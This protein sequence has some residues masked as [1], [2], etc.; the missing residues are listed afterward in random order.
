MIEDSADIPS[1]DEAPVTNRIKELRKLR[2]MSQEELAFKIGK[3][4]SYISRIE[5]GKR[6]LSHKLMIQIAKALDVEPV[7]VIDVSKAFLEVDITAI[8]ADDHELVPVTPSNSRQHKMVADIPAAYVTREVAIVLGNG[9]FP[10]HM[11]GD[12]IVFS[13]QKSDISRLIGRDCIV[14]LSNGRMFLKTPIQGT[15]PH[16]FHLTSFN[17]PTVND[18]QVIRFARIV[19]VIPA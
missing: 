7:E 13:W 9:L 18:A 5:S 10:R 14:Q 11:D 19:A 6:N 12:L 8:I 3:S 17:S 1:A 15:A 4:V 2:N 16:L